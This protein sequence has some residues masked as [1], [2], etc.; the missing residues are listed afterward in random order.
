MRGVGKFSR[1]SSS[2]KVTVVPLTTS[3][4]S[5]ST[6]GRRTA[7]RSFGFSTSSFLSINSVHRR[8]RATVT[9]SIRLAIVRPANLPIPLRPLTFRLNLAVR[10]PVRVLL[11]LAMFRYSPRTSNAVIPVP[12][13]RTVTASSVSGSGRSIQTLL[14]SASHALS[15]SSFNAASLDRYV[16]PRTRVS[17]VFTAKCAISFTHPPMLIVAANFIAANSHGAY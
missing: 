1:L 14:A 3:S 12:S 11:S 5:S 13:S 9:T 2:V 7:S 8:R 4:T 17:R 10:S 16:S 6:N 15:T